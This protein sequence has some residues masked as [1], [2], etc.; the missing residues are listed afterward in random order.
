MLL[1]ATCA[2]CALW[3]GAAYAQPSA[4][5]LE[6]ARAL[7]KE[8]R[9]LR[10]AGKLAE[11]RDKLK[12]AHALGQTPITGLELAR[13]HNALGELVEAREVCLGVGRIPVASDET[14]RSA[15]A[16]EQAALLARELQP[17]IPALA[18][19]LPPVQPPPVVAVD[20]QTIPPAALG[21]ARRVNPGRHE[22]T[23]TFQDGRQSH[24]QV[25]V[26]ESELQEVHIALP[27][28]GSPVVGA[29]PPTPVGWPQPPPPAPRRAPR[30]TVPGYAWAGFA[31]AT[32]GAVV[33]SLTGLVATA[34]ARDLE[35]SCPDRQCSPDY[36]QELDRARAL[37]NVST[38]AFAVG[39]AGLILGITGVL[40]SGRSSTQAAHVTPWVG[41]GS[42]GVRGAF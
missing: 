31:I 30:R 17:R 6:T 8:G 36:H 27:A 19:R 32:G 26:R 24:Q 1:G 29:P 40:A 13:T 15:A 35:S 18:F 21:E 14:D 20:G 33:G 37:G 16:R 2:A 11:A 38:A 41:A 3:C 23:A 9:T 25:E 5:D 39:G 4:A 22:V 34:R 7:Y 28:P 10:E 42:A 12:A